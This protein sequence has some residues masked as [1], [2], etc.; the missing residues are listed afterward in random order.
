MTPP[1]E[2]PEPE[3]DETP[4]ELKS[5]SFLAADNADVLAADVVAEIS[6][7]MVVRIK[8]GG[9]GVELVA[10][11]TAGENDEITVNE[12]KVGAD[13][14]VKVDA[15]FPVDIVVKNTKS[16]KVAVYELKVGKV[17]STVMTK[18][19]YYRH[20]GCTSMDKDFYLAI[21]PKT[22][23]PYVVYDRKIEGQTKSNISVA[24][25]ENGALS[26]VFD[27]IADNASQH[28]YPLSAEFAADGTPYIL[29]KGGES[30][31]TSKCVLKKFNG[32]E[33][34]D[35]TAPDYTQKFSFSFGNPCLYVY[36]NYAGFFACGNDKTITST[37]RMNA[38]YLYN[39]SAW[40]T[41]SLTLPAYGAKG[42]SDGMFYQATPVT[43][44]D[45]LYLVTSC[46]LYGHYMYKFE[47][48][49][50]KQVVE[51]FLP[52]GEEYA[53]PTNMKAVADPDGNIY[54]LSSHSKNPAHQVYKYNPAKATF[55]AYAGKIKATAASLGSVTEKFGIGINPVTGQMVGCRDNEETQELQFSFVEN[56]VWQDWTTVQAGL[57]TYTR[58]DIKFDSKGNGYCLTCDATD[59]TYNLILYT[60]GPEEDI[61]PE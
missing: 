36:G 46:N 29:Y 56:G 35:L 28:C 39:G 14:K 40:S 31:S 10:T 17:L 23:V 20:P 1:G 2:N 9:K 4:A 58:Y 57:T 13:G 18:I 45:G 54:I 49:T 44:K 26:L 5:F 3:K 8:G 34:V 38:G 7:R 61:L 55:E 24:K 42:G 6:E 51:N 52:D 37:Y 41:P 11:V 15:T 25:Y 47:D 53:I 60:I 43:T 27:A 19:A 21:D 16:E 59:K 12:E 33:W 50:F 22:D 32:T 48:G 30:G